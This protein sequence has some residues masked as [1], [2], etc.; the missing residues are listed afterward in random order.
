[1]TICKDCVEQVTARKKWGPGPW[2]TEPDYLKF[3]AHGFICQLHRNYFSWWQGYV[4]LTPRN[5]LFQINADVI[6]KRVS[7][8]G[9]LW[10]AYWMAGHFES[11]P[12]TDYP[13]IWWVGGDF[14]LRGQAPADYGPLLARGHLEGKWRYWSI[15]D[16]KREIRRLAEQLAAFNVGEEAPM[17]PRLTG[18]GLCSAEQN[19]L[20]KEDVECCEGNLVTIG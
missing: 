18:H 12:Q 9:Q 3:E 20:I 2:Q 14:N 16:A 10:W 19:Q 4:G 6:A 7:M 15:E 8:E 17:M 11:F 1:V 5:E 13:G